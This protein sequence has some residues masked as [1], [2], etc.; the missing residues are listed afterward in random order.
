MPER[1]FARLSP[2]FDVQQKTDK[3]TEIPVVK[4]TYQTIRKLVWLLLPVFALAGLNVRAD[5]HEAPPP[6]AVLE[7]FSCTYNPGKDRGDLDAATSY[8]QKQAE[9]AGITRAP[10]YLWTHMKGTAPADIVWVNVHESLIAYGAFAD[11]GA[12]SSEMIAVDERYDTV[13]TC[14]DNLG[15]VTP[16]IAPDPEGDDG[17]AV[18]LA[19]YACNFRGASGPADLPDLAS[20]VAE[21]N[22]ALGDA[23][24]DAA[25]QIV[26]LTA[27]PEGPDVVLVA[28]AD[29][30]E[31]WASNV[32]ALNTTPA[33]QS[34]V[35]HFNAVVDCGMNLWSSEQVIGGGDG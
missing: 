29:S 4:K 31:K 3:D 15:V 16:V 24:L 14:Q 10:A 11:A 12:A 30:T 33:G 32:A 21:T 25:F 34:L 5:S 23:G 8:Y 1:G 17:S 26:P 35:R 9:K 20:H 18:T 6:P 22:A 27:G 2:S 7:A 19:T 28:V 13:A